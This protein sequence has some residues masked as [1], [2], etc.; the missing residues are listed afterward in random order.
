MNFQYPHS[1]PSAAERAL[2][3]AIVLDNPRL[4]PTLKRACIE[5][6]LDTLFAFLDDLDGDP[7]LEPNGDA[8]PSL[9]WPI[10]GQ[11]V[12]DL[13]NDDREEDGCDAEDDGTT[14]PNL[15]A[16]EIPPSSWWYV[17]GRG[18]RLVEGTQ[19]FWGKGKGDDHELAVDDEGEATNEDGGDINDESHDALFGAEDGNTTADIVGGGSDRQ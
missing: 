4:N 6:T 19:A 7:D 13:Q 15:G 18:S 5:D 9:G 10:T 11:P 1:G 2:A 16:P 14:E 8:E 12:H 17:P 3:L